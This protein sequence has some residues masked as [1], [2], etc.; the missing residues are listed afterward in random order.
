MPIRAMCREME[1]R[2]GF[3]G[4]SLWILTGLASAA[5][6]LATEGGLLTSFLVVEAIGLV[7]TTAIV[8]GL[9]GQRQEFRIAAIVLSALA[10]LF[11]LAT[12]VGMAGEIATGLAPTWVWLV[13][14][15]T[16]M[17]A[18]IYLLLA[19]IAWHHR[20]HGSAA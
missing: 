15:L 18:A 3:A 2:L 8:V 10:G 13:A 19:G 14:P 12:G 16:V 17:T 9:R 6:E 4:L 11:E 20:R 7:V 1:L 5:G